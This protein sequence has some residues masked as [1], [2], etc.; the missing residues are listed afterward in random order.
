MST[1]ELETFYDRLDKIRMTP[2][3]RALAKVR[4]AQAESFARLLHD[5]ATALK[6]FIPARA[7]KG[8]D[9]WGPEAL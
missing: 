2:A 7:R 5:L 6:K 1:T 4:L 9:M 3:D 8:Q